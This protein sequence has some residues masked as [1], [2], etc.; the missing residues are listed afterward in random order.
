MDFEQGDYTIST[1]KARLD[2]MLIHWWL[3]EESYWAKGIPFDTVEHSIEHSLCF[4]VYKGKE[5]VGFA[6]V[7]TDYSTF[8]YLADV[9]V[10]PE[11]RGK[12]LSKWLIKTIVNYP[13]LQNL[14]RWML[15]TRDAHQIYSRVGF[16]P[17][18]APERWM[19][20]YSPEVY[21][22]KN[23]TKAG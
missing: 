6:R 23:P 5:Q 15:A 16:K 12:G 11:H 4:G 2:V 9:F 14:R 8:A 13:N 1:D 20:R 22:G 3:S 21:L 10:L 19:E 18:S 17:L 7:I